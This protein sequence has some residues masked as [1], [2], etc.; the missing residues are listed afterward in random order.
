[1]QKR[2]RMRVAKVPQARTAPAKVISKAA[3]RSTTKPPLARS[4]PAD[5]GGSPTR[6]KPVTSSRPAKV[7]AKVKPSPID[8]F[9]ELIADML[10]DLAK[11]DQE[12][13][14]D[15]LQ[16]ERQVK[17]LKRNSSPEIP[18]VTST[19]SLNMLKLING[20]VQA[21]DGKPRNIGPILMNT[22]QTKSPVF[23]VRRLVF[24]KD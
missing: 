23:S 20:I 5:P 1:M 12:T 2:R 8:G 14:L 6:K 15:F 22:S 9:A 13:L 7:K 3:A 24:D 21:I 11:R 4:P 16:Y 10:N 17:P 19:G 18:L